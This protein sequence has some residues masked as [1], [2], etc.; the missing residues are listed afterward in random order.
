MCLSFHAASHYYNLLV[1]SYKL[2]AT[3]NPPVD[4]KIN[5]CSLALNC[6]DV[7]GS[8]RMYEANQ[9]NDFTGGTSLAL[10]RSHLQSGVGA[11]NGSDMEMTEE[12]QEHQY[13]SEAQ[14][15]QPKSLTH[16]T[17]K[18]DFCSP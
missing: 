18:A 9:G 4:C 7:P 8:V 5:C 14:C 6:L 12:Q 10:V 15:L 11:R 1:L 3:A 2:L 17:G 16:R 13:C